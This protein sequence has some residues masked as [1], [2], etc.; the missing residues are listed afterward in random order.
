[1]LFKIYAFTPFIRCF[2]RSGTMN[3][4]QKFQVALE[5]GQGAKSIVS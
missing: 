4:A 1:M 2:Q 3:P 5:N